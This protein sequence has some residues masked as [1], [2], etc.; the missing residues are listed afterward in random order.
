[1]K[2]DVIGLHYKPGSI[3]PTVRSSFE[4]LSAFITV[5]MSSYPLIR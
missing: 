1:M 4:L 3:K 2:Y 5:Q